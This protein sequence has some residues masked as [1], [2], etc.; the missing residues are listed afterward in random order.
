M[1]VYKYKN[2]RRLR[3]VQHISYSHVSMKI[4]K[5]DYKKVLGMLML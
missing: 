4:E 5:S 2:T 3:N 1:S